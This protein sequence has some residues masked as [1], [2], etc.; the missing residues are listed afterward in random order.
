MQH[1]CNRRIG[2]A[3][4]LIAVKAARDEEADVW[5]VESSDLPRLNV[6]ADTLEALVEKIPA[7]IQDL[8]DAGLPKVF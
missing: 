2:L 3:T 6:E 1:R 4:Q 7:A 8:K 5:F